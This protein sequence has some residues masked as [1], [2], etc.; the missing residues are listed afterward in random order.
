MTDQRLKKIAGSLLSTKNF[1]I[2]LGYFESC[3]YN[4]ARLVIDKKLMEL[5]Y[6]QGELNRE[7]G[8]RCPLTEFEVDI[9]NEVYDYI[10]NAIEVDIIMKER[11]DAEEKYIER[12]VSSSY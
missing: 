2:F 12:I 5:E 3:N 9:C 8:I 1:N 6:T 10:I 7:E 11:A 4:S